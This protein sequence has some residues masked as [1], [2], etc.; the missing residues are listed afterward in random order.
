MFEFNEE[1]AMKGNG[2][3]SLGKILPTGVYDVELLTVSKQVAKTGT[4]GF[5]FSFRVEG[6]KYPNSIYGLWVKKADGTDLFGMNIV[7]GLMGLI[8]AKSL[9]EYGK[10]IDVKDGKKVVKAFKEFDNVKCKVVIQKVY[11]FYKVKFVKRTK[12]KHSYQ[13]MVKHLQKSNLVVSLSS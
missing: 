3:N 1:L 2:G 8:G 6:A 11:D 5:D 13:L 4:I 10:E 7:Q 12:S 9:T